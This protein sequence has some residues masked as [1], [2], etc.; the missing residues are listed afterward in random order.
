MIRPESI[1]GLEAIRARRAE[2]VARLAAVRDPQARFQWLVERARGYARLPDPFRIDAYRVE[3]CQ[4]R[5]WWVQQEDAGR[6]WLA[7]DS[8][9]ITLKSI[10][11]FLADCYSGDTEAGIRSDPP[12]FLETLGLLRSLAES[13]R[14][15][16]LRVAGRLTGAPAAGAPG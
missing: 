10:T 5:L 15:T 9:A 12:V 6:M 8:D 3:G 13:R 14:A 11:G 1:P 4:V 16:V 2:L 7:S